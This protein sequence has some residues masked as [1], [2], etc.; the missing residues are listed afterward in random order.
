M[1][2]APWDRS[3]RRRVISLFATIVAVYAGLVGVLYVS[4]RNLMYHPSDYAA[5]PAASG[6]PEMR[7]AHHETADGLRLTSWYAPA[8]AGMATLLYVHGNAGTVADRVFK[9]RPYLDRGY[10]VMLVGYRGYG[11]NP[12]AP[13]EQ[14]LYRDGASA[15]A[16]LAAQGV[17]AGRVVLYGESLGTGVAVEL[18]HR[19]ATQSPVAALVLEEPFTTMGDAAQSHYPFVP[20][21]WLVKDKFDSASK[22]AAVRA[23]LYVFHGDRDRVVPQKLGKTL[24]AAASEPKTGAWIAGAGHNDLYD[25]GAAAGILRF[26]A[27]RVPPEAP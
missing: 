13:S 1:T 24:F 27:E 26:L 8:R 6:A 3:G 18:A 9:V 25:Y 2:P 5:A 19:A 11:G 22:I 20:A 12:G 14:G 4:Q 16:F 23:P 7:L 15:M 10:G 21:K 17:A